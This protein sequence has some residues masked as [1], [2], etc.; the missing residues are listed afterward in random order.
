MMASLFTESP[1]TGSPSQSRR[2]T[3]H[4][5][6]SPKAAAQWFSAAASKAGIEGKTAH[7]LRKY[8]SVYMAERG[9]TQEQRMAILGHET[10]AQTRH[11]SKSADA[12]K[13]ISGTDFA[14]FSEPVGK[15][16]KKGN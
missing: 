12:M 16:A 9:A 10:S 6:R 14:N 5:S 7:G 3:D 1:P 13:I 11:Y 8:L 4:A 15:S 2:R